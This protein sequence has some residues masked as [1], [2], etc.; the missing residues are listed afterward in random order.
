VGQLLLL[1]DFREC[2]W[3]GGGGRGDLTFIDSG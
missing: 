1:V 2:Y 3:S